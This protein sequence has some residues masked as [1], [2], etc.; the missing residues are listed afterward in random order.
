MT[1]IAGRGSDVCI[2]W[3][4]LTNAARGRNRGGM[5]LEK[6]NHQIFTTAKTVRSL[7]TLWLF[8][9]PGLCLTKKFQIN[10]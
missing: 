3:P 9:K 6:K 1:T 4:L 10:N 2:R 8:L 7:K 5:A